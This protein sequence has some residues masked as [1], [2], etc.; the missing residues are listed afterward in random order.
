M[1]SV[2]KPQKVAS[3]LSAALAI[4]VTSAT[5]RAD[6]VSIAVRGDVSAFVQ[7]LDDR[8]WQTL[9]RTPCTARVQ[10]DASVRVVGNGF[11]SPPF[12]LQSRDAILDAH[13]P[14][15]S[16]ASTG[17]ALEII[18]IVFTVA[19]VVALLTSVVLDAQPRPDHG[20]T[21]ALLVGGVLAPL[22]GGASI[23]A[24]VSLQ[25]DVQAKLTVA[26]RGAALTF[27]F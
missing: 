9:C 6:D 22:V 13:V 17:L 12:K 24:G 23:G 10:N 20:V 2:C 18:G 14:P 11:V 1:A 25:G 16:N 19:G 3:W 7:Q 26:I 15:A 8:Q 5:V 4:L 21:D 27:T